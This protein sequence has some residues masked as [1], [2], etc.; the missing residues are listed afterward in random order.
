MLQNIKTKR[1]FFTLILAFITISAKS[2]ITYSNGKLVYGDTKPYAN[3]PITIKGGGTYWFIDNKF[4]QLDL[5]PFHPRLA[6]T[7]DRIY[8]YNSLSNKYN[9]V[10]AASFIASSDARAKKDIRSFGNGLENIL[11]LRPVCY[12]WKKDED[13][14]A[15]IDGKNFAI[16]PSNDDSEQYGFLAQEVEMFLPEIVHTSDEG[17]KGINYIALIP[18]LVEAVQELQ[19]KFDEQSAQIEQ[20]ENQLPLT[21]F[22]KLKNCKIKECRVDDDAFLHV[23][24][25][26]TNSVKEACIMV[27]SILGQTEYEINITKNADYCN[28]DLSNLKPGLHIVSLVVDGMYCDTKI[29]TLSK[30]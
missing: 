11:K 22:K 20:L 18:M 16:G 30:K 28:E 24:Y 14:D 3:Y 25:V 4:F 12:K 19:S 29:V 6:G 1:V 10:Y 15:V 7:D 21:I 2:Q 5:S 26:L 17:D 23:N 9:S 8:F 27:K 13:S